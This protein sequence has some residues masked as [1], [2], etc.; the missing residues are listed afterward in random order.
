MK[1][2]VAA[3]IGGIIFSGRMVIGGVVEDA[4]GSVLPWQREKCSITGKM[5]MV[6]VRYEKLMEMVV[7]GGDAAGVQDYKEQQREE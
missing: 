3:E 2:W 7:V 6:G 1:L 5:G 4:S